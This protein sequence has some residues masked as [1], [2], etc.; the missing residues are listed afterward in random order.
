MYPFVSDEQLLLVFDLTP[1]YMRSMPSFVVALFIL[2][3]TEPP[4]PGGD[5]SGF[6]SLVVFGSTLNV[7]PGER[8]LQFKPSTR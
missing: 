2:L 5:H 8:A 3:T 1:S 4:T 7:E 6:A